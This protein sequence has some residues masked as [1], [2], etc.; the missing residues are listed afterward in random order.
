MIR[1]WRWRGVR[2]RHL[3]KKKLSIQRNSPDLHRHTLGRLATG[4]WIGV[5]SRFSPAFA[6]EEGSDSSRNGRTF[7]SAYFLQLIPHVSQR[8]SV[9]RPLGAFHH[10]LESRVRQAPQRQSSSNISSAI[11]PSSSESPTRW[12]SAASVALSQYDQLGVAGP[13][14]AR[15]RIFSSLSCELGGNAS[16]VS[17]RREVN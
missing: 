5:A 16:S 17:G 15:M 10:T 14:A 9:P 7:R 11:D 2:D 13:P 8:M 6:F 12:P 3:R 4:C 1:V